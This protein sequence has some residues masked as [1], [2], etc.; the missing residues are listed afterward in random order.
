MKTK[1]CK[2]NLTAS[3][4]KLI[5]E[6]LLFHSSVDI[7]SRWSKTECE[8]A[9]DLIDSLRNQHPKILTDNL[10]VFNEEIYHDKITEKIVDLFPEIIENKPNL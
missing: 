9:F 2:L 8:D 10:F 6:S 5:L 4:F 1:E 7:N 3:Q